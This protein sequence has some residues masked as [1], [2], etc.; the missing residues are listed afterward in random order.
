MPAQF[1]KLSGKFSIWCSDKITHFKI[2]P[3]WIWLIHSDL[4]HAVKPPSP[5]LKKA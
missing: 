3:L 1:S 2:K 5:F 4:L